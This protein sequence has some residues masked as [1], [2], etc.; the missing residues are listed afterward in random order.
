[1]THDDREAAGE[2]GMPTSHSE[3]VLPIISAVLIAGGITRLG[4][5]GTGEL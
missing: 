2:S 4:E 5:D 1:M 3:R